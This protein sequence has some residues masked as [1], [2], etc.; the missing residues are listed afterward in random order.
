MDPES[1]ALRQRGAQALKAGRVMEAIELLEQ[2]AGLDSQSYETFSYLGAAYASKEDYDAARH[3][4][5]KAV[6]L[7][8]E[9]PRAR[10]N[11][12]RA[13]QMAGDNDAARTCYEGALELDPGYTQ[14]QD[15]IDSLPSKVFNPADLNKP[16]GKAHLPGGVDERWE[17]PH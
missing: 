13:H 11:L 7:H 3:A 8:P 16:P 6:Q 1:V 10:F 4:F 17:A 2:A 14:A 5:G 15:A 9:S 12:G